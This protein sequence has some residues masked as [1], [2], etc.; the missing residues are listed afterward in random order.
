MGAED[1]LTADDDE[2]ILAG[3]VGR[4]GDHVLELGA[5]H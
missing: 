2:R 4:G 1:R 3:H 5:P